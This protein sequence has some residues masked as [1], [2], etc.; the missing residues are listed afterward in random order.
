MVGGQQYPAPGGDVGGA[1]YDK[2]VEEGCIEADDIAGK[3][4]P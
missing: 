1:L 4:N 3:G 2:A